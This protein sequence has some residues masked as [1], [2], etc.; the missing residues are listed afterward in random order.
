MR[1]IT[2]A[3][4]IALFVTLVVLAGGGV[5]CQSL[6]KWGS[7]GEDFAEPGVTQREEIYHRYGPP[8]FVYE[9]PGGGQTLVYSRSRMNRMDFGIRL[10]V[11]QWSLGSGR[12]ETES[13]FIEVAKDDVVVSVRR[14]NA[15]A[16]PGWTLWPFGEGSDGS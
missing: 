15:P 14:Y 12:S 11:A 3:R 16:S 4:S 2:R 13:L 6:E 5:G 9:K 1:R 7:A 10:M 8:L